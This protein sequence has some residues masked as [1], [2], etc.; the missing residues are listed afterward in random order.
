MRNNTGSTPIVLKKK[1]GSV[2]IFSNFWHFIKFVA[3]YLVAT[4]NKHLLC[5][6]CFWR[7][8]IIIM[9]KS[10]TEMNK[11]QKD[12]LAHYTCKII[13]EQMNMEEVMKS[14]GIPKN[15]IK[16]MSKAIDMIYEVNQYCF[17]KNNGA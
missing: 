9:K 12:F 13:D 3:V 2:F 15:L 14:H 1:C 10:K 6:R 7:Y 8:K 11:E 16:K 4:D 5:S 17:A